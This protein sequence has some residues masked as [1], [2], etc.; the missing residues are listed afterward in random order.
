MQRGMVQQKGR[1]SVRSGKGRNAEFHV[2][3]GRYPEAIV[4]SFHTGFDEAVMTGMSHVEWRNAQAAY[5]L[6]HQLN[7]GGIAREQALRKLN[8]A[9]RREKTR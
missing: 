3:W 5:A 2:V 7:R 8:E 6:A 9:R 1:F 4:R